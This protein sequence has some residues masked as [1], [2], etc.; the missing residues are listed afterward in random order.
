MNIWTRNTGIFLIT[1]LA[2]LPGSHAI[3]LANGLPLSPA[4][5]IFFTVIALLFAINKWQENKRYRAIYLGIFVFLITLKI[6]GHLLFPVGWSVCLQREI[7]RDTLLTPCEPSAQDRSGISTYIYPSINFSRNATPLHFMNELAFNYKHDSAQDRHNLPYTLKASAYFKPS[8][9]QSLDIQTNTDNTYAIVNGN[10]Q[11]V[12][13]DTT[14]SIPLPADQPTV[15]EV[16]YTANHSDANKLVLKPSTTPYYKDGGLN[17]LFLS[18]YGGLFWIGIIFL[19][20]SGVVDLLNNTTTIESSSRYRLLLAIAFAAVMFLVQVDSPAVFAASIFGLSF[21]YLHYDQSTQKRFRPLFIFLLLLISMSYVSKIITYDELFILGGGDDP[22]THES[23]ARSVMKA[24]SV[25]EILEAGTSGVF[26]YQPL[27]R[28]LA[29]VIHIILGES[30]WGLYLIQ[31]F[32]ISITIFTTTIFLFNVGGYIPVAVFSVGVTHVFTQK[33]AWPLLAHITYQEAL[34]LPL[35][36]LGV[37]GL[38]YLALQKTMRP[39][40]IVG[41]GLCIS[42]AVMIRTDWLP[43]LLLTALFMFLIYVRNRSALTSKRNIVF[44]ITSVLFFPLF[45]FSRNI[46][47]AKTPTIFTTSGYINLLEPF[48]ELFKAPQDFSF[49]QLALRLVRHYGHDISELTLLLWTNIHEHFI[50]QEGW[51]ERAWI[52]FIMLGFAAGLS[53]KPLVLF[54]VASTFI[55]AFLPMFFGSPFLQ[56]NPLATTSQYNFLLVFG[57]AI[58]TAV[59]IYTRKTSEGYE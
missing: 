17:H 23:H 52:I 20:L 30:L 38:F 2:L 15:I 19:V 6:F 46:V 26:Y 49:V 1:L 57:I 24:Q 42:A 10:R 43:V 25:R 33:Y 9:P 4:E 41:S 7:E 22:L 18:I 45:I 14:T 36:I 28:Y 12:P 11:P 8:K 13:L 48:K 16:G 44:L 56:D 21:M 34:G 3:P 29:G 5:L 58:F 40:Y 32:L 54:I 47:I 35:L 27:Y 53:K 31:T 39:M 55:L 51:Q 59:L 50:G 37:L